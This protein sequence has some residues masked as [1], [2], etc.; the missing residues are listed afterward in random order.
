MCGCMGK[1]FVVT[2]GEMGKNKNMLRFIVTRP[3][4]KVQS[5]PLV[6]P[7]GCDVTH[8]FSLLT[9]I[10]FGC[11]SHKKKSQTGIFFYFSG[12]NIVNNSPII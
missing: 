10:W 5:Q 3:R 2:R 8:C 9:I 4:K 11:G 7:G 1:C 12:E 6:A